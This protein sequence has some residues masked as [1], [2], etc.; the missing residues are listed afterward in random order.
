MNAPLPIVSANAAVPTAQNQTDRLAAVEAEPLPEGGFQGLLEQRLQ[1][2][3]AEPAREEALEGT[4]TEP[5]VDTAAMPQALDST[6]LPADTLATFFAAQGPATQPAIEA[7]SGAAREAIDL[8][9]ARDLAVEW[10]MFARPEARFDTAGAELDQ[11]SSARM[12]AAMSAD[13]GKLLPSLGRDASAAI[14]AA[15]AD[16]AAL[17]AATVD[18]LPALRVGT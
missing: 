1:S 11:D 9:L 13:Y 16:T 8:G 15:V 5:V 10:R 12:M 17:A 2:A 4:S 18:E 7:Q 14:A 6:R 3:S